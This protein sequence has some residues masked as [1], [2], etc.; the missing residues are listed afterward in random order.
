MIIRSSGNLIAIASVACV[1]RIEVLVDGAE[2][3]AALVDRTLALDAAGL[4]RLDGGPADD[5]WSGYHQTCEWT[6]TIMP[7]RGARPSER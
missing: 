1:L 4:V 6:S 3:Q 2:L 5:L 7:A